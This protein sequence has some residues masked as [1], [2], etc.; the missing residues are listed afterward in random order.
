LKQDFLPRWNEFAVIQPLK[1]VRRFGE[2]LVALAIHHAS[3][4]IQSYA[5]SLI[6]AV[7]NLDIAAIREVLRQFPNFLA[8]CEPS[9]S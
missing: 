7:D 9:E 1:P 6:T 8:T 5:A 3:P 2:D 4:A